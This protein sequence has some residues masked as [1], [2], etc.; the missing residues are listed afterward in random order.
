LIGRLARIQNVPFVVGYHNVVASLA[1]G[2]RS[3]VPQLIITRETFEQQI[4]W[5]GRRFRFISLDELGSGLESSREWRV[6]VATITFD[7]GY[8]G[9]YENAFPVLK[10]KGIPMGVFLVTD[11]VGTSRLQI[12]DEL[13]LLIARCFSG[14][15]ELTLF[16]AG[17]GIQLAALEKRK[18]KEW[19]P[20]LAME[21]LL[22]FL[23]QWRL[24]RVM[25]ALQ[26]RVREEPENHE[27]LLPLK[28]EMVREMH[29]AGV[30]IGSHSR[31]HA[32]LT[33]EAPEK[34]CDEV[35]SSRRALEG[36]LGVP[37]RHF[38]YPD[39]RFNAAVVRAIAESGYRYGYTTCSHKDREY[40]LLTIP[41][42]LFGEGC[43]RGVF[44]RFSP[45]I[46]SC[47]V[48]GVFSALVDCPGGHG[49]PEGAA[50]P[51]AA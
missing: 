45:A 11:L 30:V 39:G 14:W 3:P 43:S 41:H 4:D 23:P 34:V 25:E 31:T 12:H 19:S 48:N 2:E 7:D 24:L 40:P 28:W 10:K 35:I 42:R 29:R 38:A 21:G 47:H 49:W 33:S 32:L 37:I 46:M 5:L 22:R 36:R 15:S 51:L 6:P 17:L 1:I 16:L 27:E 13:C 9:V 26:S 44:G 50:Q 18:T 20:L 8:R